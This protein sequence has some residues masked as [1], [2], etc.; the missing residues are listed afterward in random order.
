MPRQSTHKEILDIV[1]QATLL[2]AKLQYQDILDNWFDSNSDSGTDSDSDS[3][4]DSGSKDLLSSTLD[5]ISTIDL[6][7]NSLSTPSSL[8]P[9]P[10]D[11]NFRFFHFNSS[12]S[13]NNNALP[14]TRL[15]DTIATL[16]DEVE[17]A[18]VL[19]KPNEP[20]P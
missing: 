20:T 8:P 2:L 18:C 10:Y 4:S 14:Y 9:L 17:K 12:D 6:S 15:H 16:C 1:D 11:R 5:D 13:S 7:F 19:H 3:D